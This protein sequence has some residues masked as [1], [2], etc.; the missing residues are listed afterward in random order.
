MH[1]S[2]L[3]DLRGKVAVVTGGG[4]GIGRAIALGLATHGATVI[5]GGRNKAALDETV[6]ILHAAAPKTEPFGIAM[7]VELEADVVRARDEILSSAGRI[8]ILV[9]NAGIDPHYATLEKTRPE[10]WD[11]IVGVNLTGVFRCCRI[12]GA[13]MIDN[14]GGSIINISSVAGHIGLKRQVPY[15]A[16]KGGVEQ[17]TKALAVD[18]AEHGVRVNAIAYG[19]IDTDLTNSILNHPH[20]GPRLLSRVPMGRF[21]SLDDV[22]GAAIFLASPAAQYVTGHSLAVDGGWL[23]A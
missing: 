16:T 19:F 8:D 15:C 14:K 10:E 21:G 9:N 18:W 2:R 3:F 11:R 22:P 1:T 12:L 4:R 23:A 6:H 13:S 7:D 5:I 20:I 17:I